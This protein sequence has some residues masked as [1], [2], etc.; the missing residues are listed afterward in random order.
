MHRARGEGGAAARHKVGAPESRADRH[1]A[2]VVPARTALG[3][4]AVGAVGGD[5]AHGGEAD[6]LDGGEYPEAHAHARL[7]VL[8]SLYVYGAS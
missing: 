2:S 7:F 3:R 6:Q 5:R 8:P 4:A 1:F